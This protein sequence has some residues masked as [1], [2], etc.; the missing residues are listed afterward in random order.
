MTMATLR[1]GDFAG[2]SSNGVNF[3][4]SLMEELYQLRKTVNQLLNDYNHHAHSGVMTDQGTLTGETH[5]V[6]ASSAQPTRSINSSVLV[7]TIT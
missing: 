2:I 6:V 7:G 1:P 4:I 3:L 5:P